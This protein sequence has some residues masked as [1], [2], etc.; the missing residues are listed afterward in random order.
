MKIKILIKIIDLKIMM[1]I[2]GNLIKWVK[3]I[4]ITV[5]KDMKDQLAL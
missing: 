4:I 3:T 1:K 2:N 5:H